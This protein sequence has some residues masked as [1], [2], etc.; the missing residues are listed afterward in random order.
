MFM[1]S[2]SLDAFSRNLVAVIIFQDYS[3][4]EAADVL[5][6][7]RRTVCRQF[8]EAVDRI[9]IIETRAAE[10]SLPPELA[11]LRRKITELV[12]RNAVPMVQR[13]IDAVREDGQYQAMK[14]SFE[15]IDLYPTTGPDDSPAQ[16]SLAR[17]YCSLTL[18]CLPCHM[19]MPSR[20][21]PQKLAIP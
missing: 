13:A 2:G 15:M 9:S 11:A 7:G 14:Y 21:I 5:R 6:C 19:A 20:R 12:A 10:T 16:D 4:D 17:G 3:Q 1:M 8:P 18:G